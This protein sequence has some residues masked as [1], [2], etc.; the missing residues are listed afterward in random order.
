M[1]ASHHSA[2]AGRMQITANHKWDASRHCRKR[3]HQPV[4]L[5][6]PAAL[7]IRLGSLLRQFAI[8]PQKI[9]VPFAPFTGAPT[10]RVRRDVHQMDDVFGC[11]TSLKPSL[12]IGS[13][14]HRCWSCKCNSPPYVI[15]KHLGEPPITQGAKAL[16]QA[17][18]TI[19]GLVWIIRSWKSWRSVRIRQ[20]FGIPKALRGPCGLQH[21]IVGRKVI[22]LIGGFMIVEMMVLVLQKEHRR[23]T[24][25]RAI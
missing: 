24:T 9:G 17:R 25:Q 16:G 7:P 3:L 1:T 8:W 5:R 10:R 14:K 6:E 22:G 19:R 23:R 20:E 13:D 18:R 2:F 21:E 15:K 11:G 12:H 4:M